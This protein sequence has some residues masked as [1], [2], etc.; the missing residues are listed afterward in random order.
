MP[1]YSV[2]FPGSPRP[3]DF[4]VLDVDPVKLSETC[5]LTSEDVAALKEL[6]EDLFRVCQRAKERGVKILI[7]AEHRYVFLP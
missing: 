7:D 6:K 2:P 1:K 4:D 3:T 5:P